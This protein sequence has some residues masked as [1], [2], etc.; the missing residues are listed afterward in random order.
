MPDTTTNRPAR[1]HMLTASQI[2]LFTFMAALL[3][4]F[5]DA[6]LG[7]GLTW[8]NDPYWTYWITKT[9]LIATVLGLGSALFGIGVG[10]RRYLHAGPHD[11]PDDLLLV[12]LTGRPA[13]IARVA[14]PAAHLDHRRTGSLCRDLPRIPDGIVDM[15]A[16]RKTD[17]KVVDSRANAIHALV[18]G[19]VI[20]VVAGGLDNIALGEFTGFTWFLVRLLLTVP[21]VFGWRAI[22][23][24]DLRAAVV[25]GLLLA[26][27]WTSYS[28]FLGPI[29]LP[30]FPLRI[31]DMAPPGAAVR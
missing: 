30:N 26:L 10:T 22:V 14:R 9:F 15:E 31:L 4:I 24:R 27:I 13:V 19:I 17:A 21:F 2:T 29:G 11:H 3:A 7:H 8:E 25:G 16:A 23:G 28:Q 1:G 6:A 5:Y 20:T 12:P 18:I